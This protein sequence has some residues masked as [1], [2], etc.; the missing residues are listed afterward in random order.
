MAARPAARNII[1][2]KGNKGRSAAAR[3][4]LE[5]HSRSPQDVVP[6]DNMLHPLLLSSHAKAR[7]KFRNGKVAQA[8][9]R[10]KENQQNKQHNSQMARLPLFFHATWN[11]EGFPVCISPSPDFQQCETL[12][13]RG[14]AAL[15]GEAD[16]SSFITAPYSG[17]AH[18]A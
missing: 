13:S 10:G 11:H 16:L 15:S 14:V 3:V 12:P 7:L 5:I 8:V 18:S 1:P 17:N 4:E 2:S 6:S 9:E